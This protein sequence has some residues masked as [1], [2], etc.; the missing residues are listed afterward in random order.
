MTASAFGVW[1]RNLLLT[2]LTRIPVPDL[3]DCSESGFGHQLLEV[4]SR[5]RDRA[6]TETDWRELDT[7]VLG[8]Y[9]LGGSDRI[10]VEDG[11]QRA[12][13][14]WDSGRLNSMS[15]ASHSQ[16][17]AY[18]KAFLETVGSWLSTRNRQSMRAEILDLPTWSPLRIVRFVLQDASLDSNVSTIDPHGT[19]NEV[20]ARIG[21][22]L[23]VRLSNFVTGRRELRVHGEREVI[24]I[25]PSAR[26]HWLGVSALEDADTV[27]AESISEPRM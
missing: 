9:G 11:L 1:M 14:Q 13:Y 4:C 6:P 26:R 3:Q 8:L 16:L 19:L 24:I 21:R 18:A 27:I 22:R 17:T 12:G 20:V 5:I 15:P 2:D 10:V 25:K 7:A 23:N